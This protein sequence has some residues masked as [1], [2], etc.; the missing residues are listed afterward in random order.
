MLNR[1]NNAPIHKNEQGTIKEEKGNQ[2]GSEKEKPLPR[3]ISKQKKKT[4]LK[5]KPIYTMVPPIT[6]KYKRNKKAKQSER[7]N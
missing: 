2:Y 6:Y 4:L 1:K 5:T 3:P 7:K